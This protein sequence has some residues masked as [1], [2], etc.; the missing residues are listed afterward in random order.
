MERVKRKCAR[1]LL[2]TG[3]REVLLI[4]I[5]NPYGNWTGWITPGGGLNDGESD[6]AGIRR[7]LREELG[8]TAFALGPK[9]WRRVHA[10]PWEGRLVEQDETFFL[11]HVDRFEP[12]A[13]IAADDPEMRVL[14]EMRWWQLAE[15][16]ESNE[17]FA[18]RR[19]G[20]L[21]EEL[22]THGAPASPIEIGV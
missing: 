6:E 13:Q 22:F 21:V 14:S 1:A 18:P 4:R 2:V 10:F 16:R 17:I 15:I 19:L 3:A 5:V 11:I 20:E 7:E 12:R 9:I 8:L